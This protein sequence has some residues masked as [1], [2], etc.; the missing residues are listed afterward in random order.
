MAAV[1]SGDDSEFAATVKAGRWPSPEILDRLADAHEQQGST[2]RT[3]YNRSCDV[4][5]PRLQEALQ[6]Q[7]GEAQFAAHNANVHLWDTH[8]DLYTESGNAVRNAADELRSL[9]HDL[10][11]LIEDKEPQYQAAIR[12]GKTIAAQAILTET[13]NEAD[14]M[15]TNRT[16]TATMY[17]R[18]VNFTAPLPERPA[19][20]PDGQN[21]QSGTLDHAKNTRLPEGGDKK[22]TAEDAGAGDGAISGQSRR[23]VETGLPPNTATPLP[24]DAQRDIETD[25][26]PGVPP[27]GA[28]SPTT[29]P[30]NQVPQFLGGSMGRAAGGGSGA[31]GG[32]SALSGLGSGL[33]PGL[34]SSGM[35]TSPASSLPSAPA[36]Q[37]AA[38]PMA[39]A[40]SSFQS[41]LA[42]GMGAV[43]PPP[44]AQQPIAQQ[45]MAAQQPVMGSPAVG[46]GPAGVP[47][48]P[49]GVLDGG[50][51][52]PVQGGPG[53]GSVGG[54]PLMPPAAMGGG[55]PLAPYSA[56]GAG[57]S[58][59]GG[60]APTSAA[61]AGQGS[62]GGA[63]PAGGGLAAPGPLVSGGSGSGL[64]SGALG[65]SSSEVNPDLLRAQR[66]LAE[67]VR[68]SEASG[69]LPIWAVSVLRLPE[70]SSVVVVAN[71]M[72]AGGYLPATVYLPIPARL[73]VYDAALPMGWAEDWWCCQKPSK[74]LV[75]H[76]EHLRK[77]V[78]GVS[79]SVVVTTEVWAKAPVDWPGGDFVGVQ[80]RDLLRLLSEAPKLDG[81]HQHRLATVDPALAQRVTAL[82]DRGGRV[83]E[84]AAATL[85]N[86]VYGPAKHGVDPQLPPLMGDAEAQLLAAVN[87]RTATA[88]T[89][90]AYE[91][92][93]ADRNEELHGALSW[94]ETYGPVDHDGSKVCRDSI[95]L[96]RNY[97][98]MV[99]MI[100]LVRC[101]KTTPPALAEMAY[102]ALM[103]GF[104]H[105]VANTVAAVERQLCGRAS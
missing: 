67:L 9:Q 22:T 47:V 19:T 28:P 20:D 37:S 32:G 90:A 78:A 59:A 61:S 102:C 80:H 55:V 38:S 99:R 17:V 93:V 35:P 84:V 73:A 45:A 36:A 77:R 15:V 69:M 25:L 41:G 21:G 52:G 57:P 42:S 101:W 103:A 68:G 87:T 92:A 105:E 6:G 18:G 64:A 4:H 1:S 43:S 46:S 27:N 83:S 2:L 70:G 49:H 29:S 48:A 7:A 33:N 11:L 58:S 63:A 86:A 24:Q 96:Y 75:D 40:G 81:G 50:G 74:I 94:P 66:V 26:P 62:S 82:A 12:S 71:N 89:W 23:D 16:G 31:G 65:A 10:R 85:T 76:F 72:G 51:G 44:V 91:T 54:A 60:G 30:L 95:R 53:A 5:R 79:I 104:G 88:D 39:N 14:G 97:F 100:E 98:R 13:V 8:A 3:A 34:G 56:P